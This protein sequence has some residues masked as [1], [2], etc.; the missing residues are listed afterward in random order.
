MRLIVPDEVALEGHDGT[1][2]QQFQMILA[3]KI[4]VPSMK[5]EQPESAPVVGIHKGS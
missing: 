2:L 1:G 3:H 4:A 5:E